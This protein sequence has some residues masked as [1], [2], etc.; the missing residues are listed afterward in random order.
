MKTGH[1]IK[2]FFSGNVGMLNRSRAGN[3][4]MFLFLLIFAIY[5][6]LPIVLVLLQ[7]IKPLNELFIYPPRFFVVNPTMDNFK[8]LPSL[9]AASKVPFA[10]YIFNS[11]FVSVI[12][13]IGHIILASMCA[14]VFTKHQFIGRNFM[15]NMVVLS[16]MFST[17]VTG[18]PSYIIMSG[19]HLT[20]TYWA[21]ILPAFSSSLGL[22]LMKQFMSSNVPDAIIEAARIDG[23]GEFRLFWRIVMPMVKPA[24]LTLI[25]FSFQNLWNA[26][27]GIYIQSEDI[28]SLSYAI[29]QIVSGGI[30]RAGA[31]AASIVIMMLL[32]ILVFFFTQSNIVETM[33]SSGIKE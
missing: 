10:R 24:W 29:S 3:G 6:A 19:L 20:D 11:L 18:I 5:S 16:L 22:Y 17:A 21:L 7:S 33:S 13:T 12:G 26:S 9:M 32:P 14:Y 31:S 23:S 27:G 4:V 15:F 1:K 28:K 2:G 25:V 30:A 8:Q